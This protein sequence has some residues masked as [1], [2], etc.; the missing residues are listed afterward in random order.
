MIAFRE[1][2][3]SDRPALVSIFCRAFAAPPWNES[4][5]ENDA[6]RMIDEWIPSPYFF[7]LIAVADANAVAFAFGRIE[8]WQFSRMFYLKEL[9][10]L[11]EVQRSG[12]G[13]ALSHELEQRLKSRGVDLIYLHSMKDSPASKFYEKQQYHASNHMLMFTRKIE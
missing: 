4:W 5:S 8:S 11:P 6:L 2:S 9:C 10:V 7:G 1:I 13:M 12:V 3:L